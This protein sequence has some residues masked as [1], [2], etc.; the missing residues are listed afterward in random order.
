[1][2]AAGHER[3]ALR[4]NAKGGPKWPLAT[5]RRDRVGGLGEEQVAVAAAAEEVGAE[6]AVQT[7]EPGAAEQLVVAVA[8][9][10]GVASAVAADDVVARVA[11][12]EVVV[13]AADH[14]VVP[15]AAVEVERGHARE[16][17]R[18]GDVVG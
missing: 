9:V 6:A 4:V 10:H 16:I 13:G 14:R 2:T 8:A 1:M 3:A 17:E 15:V 11:R 12:D 7:V 18:R 5:V